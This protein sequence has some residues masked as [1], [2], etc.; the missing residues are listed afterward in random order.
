M[1][2]SALEGVEGLGPTR[3][4]RLLREFGSVAAVRRASLE[5]LLALKWLPDAT[6]RAVYRQLHDPGS[7]RDRSRA[8]PVPRDHPISEVAT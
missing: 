6:A 7:P 3:R 5:E 4:A 8:T 2:R 1:T